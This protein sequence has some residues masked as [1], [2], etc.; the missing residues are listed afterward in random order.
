MDKQQ[1]LKDYIATA[2]DLNYDY[3]KVNK[4]FPEIDELLGSLVPS[5]TPSSLIPSIR[6]GGQQI[7]KDYIATAEDLNYD[8]DKVNQLFPELFPELKK[9]EEQLPDVSTGAAQE[10]TPIS[11][12]DSSEESLDSSLS[13]KSNTWAESLTKL[14]ADKDTEI[15][16]DPSAADPVKKP[17]SD[18]KRYSHAASSLANPSSLVVQGLFNKAKEYFSGPQEHE[19]FDFGDFEGQ[20]SLITESIPKEWESASKNHLEDLQLSG[21][22]D[23]LIKKRQSEIESINEELERR[24]NEKTVLRRRMGD[25]DFVDVQTEWGKRKEE[26]ERRLSKIAIDGNEMNESSLAEDIFK[27]LMESEFIPS[28]SKSIKQLPGFNQDNEEF[29]KMVGD[30][31]YATTSLPFDLDGDGRFNDRGL[32]FELGSNFTQGL[33]SMV[34]AI[35]YAVESPFQSAEENEQLRAISNKEL[36]DLRDSNTFYQQ[37]ISESIASGNVSNATRQA[38]GGVANAAPMVISTV[39]L[40]AATGGAGAPAMLAPLTGAVFNGTIGGVQTYMS[41]ADLKDDDGNLIYSNSAALGLSALSGVSSAAINYVGGRIFMNAAKSS[42]ARI[43]FKDLATSEVRSLVK[44]KGFGSMMGQYLKGFAHRRGVEFT[45]EGSIELVSRL[46]YEAADA[47]AQGKDF[48]LEGAMTRSL[49][50]L[51]VGGLA[52][53]TFGIL[54]RANAPSATSMSRSLAQSSDVFYRAEISG[55]DRGIM[56]RMDIL[57]DPSLSASER[58]TYESQIGTLKKQR[59]DKINE[60]SK[61]LLQ[62]GIANPKAFSDLQEINIQIAKEQA[63]ARQLKDSAAPDSSKL[64]EVKKKN[65]ADLLAKRE[66]ILSDNSAAPSND[67]VFR[68]R[69]TEL[70]GT[71]ARIDLA[72]KEVSAELESLVEKRGA[73]NLS[74]KQKKSLDR[75][76]DAVK[77]IIKDYD[78]LSSQGKDLISKRNEAIEA[79]KKA[80][81]QASRDSAIEMINDIDAE[82]STKFHNDFLPELKVDYNTYLESNF[83]SE[84]EVIRGADWDAEAK[85][86]LTPSKYSNDAEFLSDLETGVWGMLTPENPNA[87]QLTNEENAVLY[88][89]AIEWLRG[90]NYEP[91]PIFGKYGNSENSFYVPNLS[92]SDAIEFAVRFKQESVAHSEGLVYQDGSLNPRSGGQQI[93]SDFGDFYSTINVGGKN[94]DFQ[95]GYDFDTKVMPDGSKA[96]EASPEFQIFNQRSSDHHVTVSTNQDGSILVSPDVTGL[97]K[98][99]ASTAQSM[100]NALAKSTGKKVNLIIGKDNE[101]SS[102]L[103]N[104]YLSSRAGLKEGSLIEGMFDGDSDVINIYLNPRTIS[105]GESL[106]RVLGEEVGHALFNDYLLNTG[107]DNLVGITSQLFDILGS[108]KS[109]IDMLVIATARL[110]DYSEAI[111]SI[112]SDTSMK[113]TEITESLHESLRSGN[114]AEAKAKLSEVESLLKDTRDGRLVFTEVI[115]SALSQYGDS[116]ASSDSSISASAKK[117]WNKIKRLIESVVGKIWPQYASTFKEGDAKSMMD[118]MVSMYEGAK[119]D[120]AKSSLDTTPTPSIGKSVFIP[121][122]RRSLG[123]KTLDQFKSSNPD[124]EM[125]TLDVVPESPFT[126][127]YTETLFDRK[128]FEFYESSKTREFQGRSH[129]IEWWKKTNFQ[130]ESKFAMNRGAGFVDM[131]SGKPVFHTFK[132]DGKVLDLEPLDNLL[133]PPKLSGAFRVKVNGAGTYSYNSFVTDLMLAFEHSLGDANVYSIGSI[134][135]QAKFHLEKVQRLEAENNKKGEYWESVNQLKEMHFSLLNSVNRDLEARG[136][137]AME[138]LKPDQKYKSPDFFTLADYLSGNGLKKGTASVARV[139]RFAKEINEAFKELDAFSPFLKNKKYLQG[140]A[141]RQVVNES[142]RADFPYMD[143]EHIALEVAKED[144]NFI[145]SNNIESPFNWV[146]DY[147]EQSDI[148]VRDTARQLG[149]PFKRQHAS[150]FHMINGI[151]SN[152]TR[153]NPNIDAAKKIFANVLQSSSKNGKYEIDLKLFDSLVDSKKIS[154]N[155]TR[156]GN[157]RKALVEA[158]NVLSQH[159]KDGNLNVGAMMARLSGM[160]SKDHNVF[161]GQDLFGPKIGSYVLG[162]MGNM[163][164]VP[165]DTHVLQHLKSLSEDTFDTAFDVQSVLPSIDRMAEELGIDHLG[166]DDAMKIELINDEVK[167]LGDDSIKNKWCSIVNEFH[168]NTSKRSQKTMREAAD[169]IS[170]LSNKFFDEGWARSV[171]LDVEGLMSKSP[172]VFTDSNGNFRIPPFVV[173]Q[174]MYAANQLASTGTY[175]TAKEAFVQTA[176]LIGVPSADDVNSMI[177]AVAFRRV[178]RQSSENL[179]SETVVVPE[180]TE[181]KQKVSFEA[182]NIADLDLFSVLSMDLNDSMRSPESE[183]PAVS[184]GDVSMTLTEIVFNPL[185][186]SYPVTKDG[187]FIKSADEVYVVDGKTYVR[188]NVEV[189]PRQEAGRIKTDKTYKVPPSVRVEGINNLQAY[190]DNAGIAADAETVYNSM[191]YDQQ[192]QVMDSGSDLNIQATASLTG[193]RLRQ[194]AGRAAEAFPGLKGEIL[195]NPENYI[196]RQNLQGIKSRMETMSEADLVSLMRDDALGRLQNRNDD[197]GAL[198]GAELINRAVQRGDMEA[199]PNLIEELSKIGTTAGRILRQFRELKMSVPEGFSSVIQSMVEK[200]GNRLSPEQ[201]TKLDDIST[202]MYKARDKYNELKKKALLGDDVEA[203]LKKAVDDLSN[204]EKE[205][206]TMVNNL[207]ERGWGEIGKMLIQGNLLTP[208]SQVVNVGANLVNLFGKGFVDAIAIPVEK[209]ANMFGMHSEYN[210]KHSFMAYVHGWKAFGDGLGEATKTMFT[211][212]NVDQTVE[213]NMHR[214]F[215]PIQSLLAIMGKGDIPLNEKGNPSISQRI[216]LGVSATLGVPAEVMFRMLSI[217]DVPFRRYAETIELYRIAKDKGLEGEA[218]RTFMR[219]PDQASQKIAVREGRKLTFQEETT[220]SEFANQS[221]AYIEKTLGAGLEYIVGKGIVDPEQVSKFVVATAIPYRTTPANILHESLTY[222]SPYYAAARIASGVRRKDARSVSE[223]FGKMMVG[224]VATTTAI[225]LIK[226]GLM[227]APLDWQD[228][229]KKNLSYDQF[230]PS[231]INISGIMRMIRGEDHTKKPDDYFINYEKLGIVGATMGAVAAGTDRFELRNRNYEDMS[232]A[233]RAFNDIIGIS[234]L[235]GVSHMMDQSF[236]QGMQTLLSTMAAS[237]GSDDWAFKVEKWM[238]SYFKAASATVLPNTLSAMNRAQ[239]EFLPDMRVTRDMSPAERLVKTL[240]YTIKDRTFNTDDVP[241]RVDWKGNRIKQNPEGANP[242]AYQLFDI[243]KARQAEADPV[244]NEMWRLY[245]STGQVPEVLGTPHYAKK[246]SLTL[247]KEGTFR[248][249]AAK[250]ELNNLSRDYTFINDEE[251]VSERI[252]LSTEALNNLMELSGKERYK[253]VQSLISSSEYSKMSDDNKLEALNS[254][255]KKYKSKIAMDEG[256]FMPHTIELLNIVQD[257]YESRD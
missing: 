1:L 5:G 221:A 82:L 252:F 98:S 42:G 158:N 111:G 201:K 61:Q 227:S 257:I 112:P 256:K 148:F 117:Q 204:I 10:D 84:P 38:L 234:P 209:L 20:M 195:A 130:S 73:D 110:S 150:V 30:R 15:Q 173:Q 207:V 182:N 118:A 246:S 39:A 124:V 96:T 189:A 121:K 57:K 186:G 12:S 75:E 194:T 196:S 123:S 133:S 185:L 138:I 46:V 239:R 240:E 149:I 113:I 219:H 177:S 53:N 224:S 244:S 230:P 160:A 36:A 213:W 58:A 152:G 208:M 41:I 44:E 127:E 9:K 171:G 161:L 184:Q 25:G 81:D 90:K 65:I 56:A 100:T 153:Q 147:R 134:K 125:V 238:Q 211:G 70:S 52:G 217:G 181:I 220:V 254:I 35:Q 76:I 136:V 31:I 243:T 119:V 135:K 3:D 165:V 223:N 64:I 159:T 251:F 54:G 198:A 32:A 183:T 4:L 86:A 47:V 151:L 154:L 29:V 18:L 191:T 85:A 164:A 94:V 17:K 168:G 129:F 140:I 77:K 232:F 144:M 89:E 167:R 2:Q 156:L 157:I 66:S 6:E 143:L 67:Q 43:G 235:A 97:S 40:T 105:D 126:I 199:I 155:S 170:N 179:Y 132:L 93:G 19:N 202:R 11:A 163:E 45:Q 51:V 21:E 60:R 27:D 23:K 206:N 120:M 7:L 72:K 122:K 172:D 180:G 26:L 101:T 190:L 237:A 228:D 231:S 63:E 253:A 249:K 95:V 108:Q 175:T 241:V 236:M 83:K 229:E 22:L 139:D 193:K 146:S 222:L 131:T 142:I 74:K 80:P 115:M 14:T 16:K 34:N 162:L 106:T 59:N 116:T 62:L 215:M 8:Y 55:L 137:D 91:I 102:D 225:M 187:A 88:Q 114:L 128:H 242:L 247:P 107:T 50:A 200:R 71:I 212:K 33:S 79:A 28:Y 197:T 210:R 166:M 103:M 49:D 68:F 203:D 216:K 248:S 226:E 188:G 205:L 174:Y 245:E 37:G 218:L 176:E 141:R 255:N 233:H 87:K 104:Q 192:R 178:G 24:E 13:E 78:D 169:F 109:G 48:D 145:S 92:M 250:R 69:N 214:G 99:D